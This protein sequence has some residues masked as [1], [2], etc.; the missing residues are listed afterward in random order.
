MHLT[1]ETTGQAPADL[2]PE[3]DDTELSD[4]ALDRENRR[5]IDSSFFCRSCRF[6]A[7]NR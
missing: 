6:C 7:P 1:D 5:S 3:I 4:E 2:M